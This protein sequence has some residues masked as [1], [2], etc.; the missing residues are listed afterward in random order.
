GSGS[1]RRL[2][3]NLMLAPLA[4]GRLLGKFDLNVP[5]PV[6]VLIVK[7]LRCASESP[8][9]VLPLNASPKTS[10]KPIE[11][12]PS[13]VGAALDVIRRINWLLVVLRKSLPEGS[14]ARSPAEL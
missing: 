5:C 9:S 7:S 13:L 14:N 8:N 4:P 6:L 2:D 3:V 12:L 11:P 10:R 1:N